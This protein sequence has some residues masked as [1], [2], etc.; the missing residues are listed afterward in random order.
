M[1]SSDSNVEWG[2]SSENDVVKHHVMY[3][4]KESSEKG[5]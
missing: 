3:P 5:W 4:Q 1:I 2:S